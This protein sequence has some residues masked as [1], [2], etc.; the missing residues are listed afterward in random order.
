MFGEIIA[1]YSENHKKPVDTLCRHNAELQIVN[2]DVTY[3]YQRVLC[4][5]HADILQREQNTSFLKAS[6]CIRQETIKTSMAGVLN[7][8]PADVFCAAH[9]YFCNIV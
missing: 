5:M 2:V 1:V 9:V 4:F 3:S 8:L 7:L 6:S